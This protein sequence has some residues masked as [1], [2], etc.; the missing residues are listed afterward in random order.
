MLHRAF[1]HLCLLRR[2]AIA[3]SFNLLMLMLVSSAIASGQSYLGLEGGLE[4]S[5][6]IDNTTTYTTGQVNKWTKAAATQTI[7]N[8][9]STVRSGANSLKINNSSLTGRRL[10]PPAFTSTLAN[11]LVIQYYRR[12]ADATNTQGS[13]TIISLDGVANAEASSGSYTNVTSANVWEKV[14]F[15]PST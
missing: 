6:T 13:Q 1:L 10:F 4:G 3:F 14:T 2:R 5:A 15:A 9:T 12:S 11:N 7:M 8:E